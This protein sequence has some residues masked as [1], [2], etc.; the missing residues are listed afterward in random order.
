M[1]NKVMIR[2]LS[3]TLQ[4]RVFQQA[5]QPNNGAANP[6]ATVTTTP[7]KTTM[8]EMSRTTKQTID[9]QPALQIKIGTAIPFN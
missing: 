4:M 6:L 7:N 9:I 1:T 2:E 5:L 3:R 8:S